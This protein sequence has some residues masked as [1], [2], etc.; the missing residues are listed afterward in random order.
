MRAD[1]C[2]K[3]VFVCWWW[4]FEDVHSK[5]DRIVGGG[6]QSLNPAPLIITC[7]K[8][9]P[10]AL[11]TLP[12]RVV[13]VFLW[14]GARVDTTISRECLLIIHLQLSGWRLFLFSYC[15]LSLCLSLCLW[16]CSPAGGC[17]YWQ[18]GG[19]N[20]RVWILTTLWSGWCHLFRE[21]LKRSNCVPVFDIG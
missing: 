3:H 9:W 21:N 18:L 2:T 14:A 5:T 11:Q 12:L 10:A 4:L 13:L 7:L 17:D 6:C 20:N 16:L 19:C 15:T 1:I 8:S